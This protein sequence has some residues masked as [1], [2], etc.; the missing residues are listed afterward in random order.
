MQVAVPEVHIQGL[1]KC[2]EG[3]FLHHI[4]QKQHSQAPTHQLAGYQVQEQSMVKPC[5]LQ[6]RRD[7][8][9]QGA[10]G[11][12]TMSYPINK[13]GGQHSAAAVELL[14]YSTRDSGSNLTNR[15]ICTA[16]VCSPR[17][18]AS[19]LNDPGARETA[20][21]RTTHHRG[22]GRP[23]SVGSGGDSLLRLDSWAWRLQQRSR[24]SGGLS[25]HRE[26][27]GP[28]GETSSRSSRNATSPTRVARLER[29]GVGTYIARHGFMAVG[30]SSTRR[31]LQ[32]S[33]I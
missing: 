11:A 29:H 13:T 3:F 30:H 21:L 10:R 7:V 23:R 33:D 16:F 1:F 18:A 22:A 9:P 19:N 12:Q 27:A 5:T 31:G 20:E 28:G 25:G 6:A 32:L 2:R 26:L 4:R 14:A 8:F 24:R 15:A 17:G